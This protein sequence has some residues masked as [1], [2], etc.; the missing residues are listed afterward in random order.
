MASLERSVPTGRRKLPMRAAVRDKSSVRR[1]RSSTSLNEME[2]KPHRK[3]FKRQA[4]PEMERLEKGKSENI[5]MLDVMFNSANSRGCVA[6]EDDDLVSE[7]TSGL[8]E[9]DV[10]DAEDFSDSSSKPQHKSSGM[11]VD[12]YM[13]RRE[14]SPLQ[15]RMNAITVI[16]GAFYC[17]LMLL[18][19][20]WLKQSLVDETMQVAVDS[21]GMAME[22]TRCLSSAWFP[23]L[24][25][26]PPLPVVAAAFGIMCHAPF[27]FIYHWSY[28][29]R[30]PTGIAR[31]KHWSRRMDQ[32]MIHFCSASM[33]YATSGR[34]DFFFANLLFNADCMYRQFEKQVHPRRNQMRIAVSV[35]A[36]TVPILRRGDWELFGTLWAIL[37]VTGFFFLL[38]PIGGWSHCAFHLGLA[39]LPPLLMNAAI[40]LP[41]SQEQLTV[42]A[43]CAALARHSIDA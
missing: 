28:A 10:S 24:H 34:V 11:D 8:I 18:S 2:P 16:P 19:G 6:G 9:T 37:G 25:A 42:A 7:A 22:G 20:E 12:E 1:R 4:T 13:A 5:S 30:L 36:Y 14:M 29:H 31:T 3:V 41:A 17:F 40:D 23:H 38:Y 15:E 27:S 35:V 39:L 26:L 43:Q 33:A 21:D 32:A